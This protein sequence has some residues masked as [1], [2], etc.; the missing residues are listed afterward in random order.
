MHSLFV[1][2]PIVWSLFCFSAICGL[3]WFCN[4]L[5]GEEG[6]GRLSFVVF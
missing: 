6:A 3:F 4:H 1:V 2:A 5:S